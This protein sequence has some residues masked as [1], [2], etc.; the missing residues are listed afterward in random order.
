M[1]F[2]THNTDG[3]VSTVIADIEELFSTRTKDS[4]DERLMEGKVVLSSIHKSKG[5]EATRVYILDR[6]LIGMRATT[7]SWQM[8]QENNLA[9]VATTRAKEAL[10]YIVTPK[11]YTIQGR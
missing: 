6:F 8:E 11:E 3:L 7:G 4:D 1:V 5:L 10:H 2:I 9:Y